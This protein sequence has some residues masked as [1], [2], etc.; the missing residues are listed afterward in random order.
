MGLDVLRW[1]VGWFFTAQDSLIS[2]LC[3]GGINEALY[4][5]GAGTS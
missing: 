4:A 1:Q 5:G 3:A 2:D